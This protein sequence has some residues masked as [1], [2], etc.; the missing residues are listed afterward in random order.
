MKNIIKIGMIAF[1]VFSML[2]CGHGKSEGKNVQ[3]DSV[4]FYTV[5]FGVV[6]S[7]AGSVEA[8]NAKGE[9][10]VTG[11]KVANAKSSYL[12]RSQLKNLCALLGR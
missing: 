8:K 3:Q 12:K 2:S 9:E 5:N 7:F 4:V 1:I 10:I 6:D 11:A